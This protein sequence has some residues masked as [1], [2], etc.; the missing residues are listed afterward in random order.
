M[1][2][3]L[4]EFLE[5]HTQSVSLK[6]SVLITITLMK[7]SLELIVILSYP[8]SYTKINLLMWEA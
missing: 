4:K 7:L 2:L 1:I 5:M 3:I 6:V 8:L